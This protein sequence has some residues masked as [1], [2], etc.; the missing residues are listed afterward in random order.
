MN[1]AYSQASF[2]ISTP[3][4]QGPLD[5]LLSLIER[6]ELDITKLALARVTN[7]FLDYVQ[8]LSNQLPEEVSGFLV[9][10]ARLMQIKSEALLPRPPA[11]ESSEPDP[12]DDLVQQ[13]I[14]YK[15]Y[16][17]IA[18]FLRRQEESG[19]KTFLRLAPPPRI[20]GKLDLVG[21]GADD[22]HNAAAAVLL[23]KPGTGD[24]TKAVSPLRV[25][26]R[27]RIEMISTMLQ[28]AGRT[29]FNRLIGAKPKRSEVVATFLALLELI[30]QYRVL[31]QQ[32]AL[33]AEI[34]IEPVGDI[35]GQVDF[36]LEFEE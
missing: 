11:R 23:F 35:A 6:A 5:V 9:I 26:V 25:T 16:K 7:A 34:E 13:L 20:E 31:V 12:G 4:Y 15:K 32:T 19:L 3:I 36:E 21:L 1:I 27:Q 28:S 17:D 14:L 29:T 33:F 22:L 30:K 10:A 2:T 18:L 24:L 8:Q